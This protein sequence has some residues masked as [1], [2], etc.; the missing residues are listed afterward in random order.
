MRERPQILHEIAVGHANPGIGESDRVR[1]LVGLNIYFQ[2]QVWLVN[3]LAGGL[4]EPEF[5]QRIRGV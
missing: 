5:F 3:L 4:E 1:S 2:W